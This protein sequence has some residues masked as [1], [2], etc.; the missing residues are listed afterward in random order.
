MQ[1]AIDACSA[2]NGG[3]AVRLAGGGRFVTGTLY[4]KANVSLRVDAGAT[5]LGSP[6]IADYSND[7]DRTMYRGEPYMDRCLIFA[8]DAQNIALEGAG[9]IDGQGKSFPNPGDPQKNRPKLVRLLGCAHV[10][11]SGLTMRNP[12]SWTNEIRYC[13]DVVADHVTIAS[14]DRPNGDGFDFDGC[15]KVRVSDCHFDTGD[16]SIC[17]QTSRPDKPCR[18]V[19]ITG[20]T[21]VSRWAGVRIG[22]LSRGA[23]TEVAVRDCTFAD[24]R[25]SGLKIQM[26]EGAELANMV[27]SHLTMRNVPRPVFLTLCQKNAWVDADMSRLP[28]MGQVRN[29]QFTDIT[30]DSDTGKD[31]AFIV[32]GVP[33]AQVQDVVFSDIKAVFH[34]GGSEADAKTVLAEL[35]PDA[36]GHERWPE[37]PVLHGT[38][39]ACGLYARHVRGLTLH[40]LALTTRVAD[41]RPAIVLVDASGYKVDGSPQ[42]TVMP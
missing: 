27:F 39:P 16:D 34:G 15:T 37:Y 7:T 6:N 29:L 11:F 3:G 12:A 19:V 35:T 31:A 32:T 22:L 33:G 25:D 40:N 23:I 17:L 41:A 18:D 10:R 30:V 20:C 26:N 24:L 8:R 2:S 38:V 42:P 21:F 4:L 9:M 5:L 13:D 36:K 1:A 14:R 28:P